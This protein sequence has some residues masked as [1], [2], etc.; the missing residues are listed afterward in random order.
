MNFKEICELLAIMYANRLISDE[1]FLEL[2]E[3]H[4][5]KNLELPYKENGKFDLQ[6]INDDEC[7]EEFHSSSGSSCWYPRLYV[8]SPGCLLQCTEG[9]YLSLRRIAY[10]CRNAGLIQC[11]GTGWWQ[12]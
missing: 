11:F 10:P 4:L 6:A 3:A 1:E 5:S 7:I 12:L 2:Y 8:G 9:I